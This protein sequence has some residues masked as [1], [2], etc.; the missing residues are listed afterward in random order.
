[1]VIWFTINFNKDTVQIFKKSRRHL[2]VL[3]DRTVTCSK[4]RTEEPL[5]FDA[6]IQNLDAWDLYTPALTVID[7]DVTQ[8]K[9]RKL[10]EEIC[11]ENQHCALGFVNV[12]IT[13]AAPTCFGTYVPS[14]FFLV[15][16]NCGLHPFVYF[17]DH[18]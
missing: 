8:V 16:I 10:Y 6:A 2:E 3:G 14:S 11:I 15:V 12:F 1:L 5:I 18:T 4:F 13:N 9:T 17:R 7:D